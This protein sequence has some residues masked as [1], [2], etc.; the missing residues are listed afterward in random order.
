GQARS[1]EVEDRVEQK[2]GHVA[3]VRPLRALHGLPQALVPERLP[4]ATGVE[5]AVRVEH[6]ALSRPE[7]QLDALVL[8]VLGDIERQ[9]RGDLDQPAAADTARHRRFMP[10]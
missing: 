5:D 1:R 10:R 8:Q 3:G 6:Y 9:V 2:V 4:A 7:S